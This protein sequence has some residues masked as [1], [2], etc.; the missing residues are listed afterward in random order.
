MYSIYEEISREI[1]SYYIQ[2]KNLKKINFNNTKT[3]YSEVIMTMFSENPTIKFPLKEKSRIYSLSEKL[4]F[5]VLLNMIKN[6]YI[7]KTDNADLDKCKKIVEDFNSKK[8]K[9]WN[10]KNKIANFI[11]K[12]ENNFNIKINLH[13]DENEF[14][15]AEDDFFI[16]RNLYLFNIDS[17]TNFNMIEDSICRFLNKK[18]F[19]RINE[20]DIYNFLFY[21]LVDARVSFIDFSLCDKYKFSDTTEFIDD[22]LS[23]FGDPKKSLETETLLDPSILHYPK[24]IKPDIVIYS[25]ISVDKEVFSSVNDEFFKRFKEKLTVDGKNVPISITD[26]TKR[27]I[28]D[29]ALSKFSLIIS[30][31]LRSSRSSYDSLIRLFLELPSGIPSID[32]WRYTE[33]IESLTNKNVKFNYINFRFFNNNRKNPYNFLG[34]AIYRDI[35]NALYAMISCPE[36]I[37]YKTRRSD[38]FRFYSIIFNDSIIIEYKKIKYEYIDLNTVEKI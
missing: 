1:R 4:G 16:P 5:I 14:I 19:N 23:L 15:K 30:S 36:L 20:D 26:L 17:Y 6:N 31:F 10:N 21:I 35:D 38:L 33:F 9:F 2:D 3:F 22:K 37:N 18:S 25:D 7:S 28:Y 27:S 11:L 8:G 32:S 12:L 29:N 13:F 24:N 34:Y